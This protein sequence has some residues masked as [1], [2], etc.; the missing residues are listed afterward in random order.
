M[1]AASADP[2]GVDQDE[3]SSPLRSV[4][5]VDRIARRSRQVAHDGSS[6]AAGS[7]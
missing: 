3:L 2:G 4:G 6:I 7:R 1:L 5:N